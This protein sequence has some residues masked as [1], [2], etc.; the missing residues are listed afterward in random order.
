M[1][2]GEN[3][4]VVLGV[5][6]CAAMFAVPASGLVVTDGDFSTWTFGSF[7]SGGSASA[8]RETMNGNPG[9]RVN[10][11]TV[12][13]GGQ[14]HAGYGVKTDVTTNLALEGLAFTLSLDVLAGPGSFG[15]GQAILIV[16]EQSGNVY[17]RSLNTTGVQNSFT[18]LQFPGTLDSGSFLKV[19]GPG[20]ATPVLDGSVAT[21]FGFAG[22]NSESGTL[23]QFYD[24]YSLSIDEPT[25]T[26]TSTATVTSTPSITATPTIT[27][28][29]SVTSTPSLTSTAS[30]TA[31][32][33]LTR[34][35]T[36]TATVTPTLTASSTV[37]PETAIGAPAIPTLGELGLVALAAALALLA[38]WRV[39][40]G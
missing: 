11:T 15:A 9:A 30:A 10:V 24:N 18:T 5:A 17:V 4:L 2:G 38:L 3:G 20:P 13:A 14:T 21:A 7:G 19:S 16:V 22:Q 39:R 28:T 8:T 31:T 1:R 40:C 32:P 26:A 23:T 27:S 37:D 34:T 6:L 35:V 12:T 29:P 25:P 33:T 36:S